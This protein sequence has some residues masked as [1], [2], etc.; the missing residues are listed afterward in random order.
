MEQTRRTELGFPADRC[1]PWTLTSSRFF[2]S[3]R[4]CREIPL[5]SAPQEDFQIKDVPP[6]HRTH[7]DG[8]LQLSLPGSCHP[9]S[10]SSSLGPGSGAPPAHCEP[11]VPAS[12]R[13]LRAS[14]AGCLRFPGR[15]LTVTHVSSSTCS[16]VHPPKLFTFYTELKDNK[17]L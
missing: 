2:S 13:L 3:Q 15:G 6:K 8:R 16:P 5:V 4:R 11:P 9:Q 10:I 1:S 12:E 7:A 14:L 17:L